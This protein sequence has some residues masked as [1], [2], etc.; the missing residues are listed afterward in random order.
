MPVY[1]ALL[2]GVNVGGARKLPMG[3]LRALVESLGHDDVRTYIQSGNVVFSSSAAVKASALEQAIRKSFGYDVTVI[4]R[5]PSQLA[6]IVER[7][8][9]PDA[10]PSDLHVGFA[11]RKPA[12]AAVASIDA[13]RYL[14]EEFA[15]VGTEVYLRLPNGMGR[16]RLPPYLDRTLGVPTTVRN[17]R[18]VEKLVEL[19]SG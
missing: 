1:A 4:L 9:F 11:V 18:T 19:A 10:G 5:T 13:D 3:E 12:K 14:P 6:R 7:N 16:A 15:V 17:W 2:R 8:P